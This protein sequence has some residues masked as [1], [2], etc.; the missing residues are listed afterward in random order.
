M[1]F[2]VLYENAAG[3][4]GVLIVHAVGV[5]EAVRAVLSQY[6]WV[7]GASVVGVV[8]SGRGVEIATAVLDATERQA[9]LAGC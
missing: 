5:S 6:P 3:S 1:K 7:V 8:E 9:F 2:S 4:I